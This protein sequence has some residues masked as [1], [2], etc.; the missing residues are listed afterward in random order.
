VHTAQCSDYFFDFTNADA[1]SQKHLLYLNDSERDVRMLDRHPQVR[2]LF[3]KYN[4]AIASSAP[5]ERVF[6]TGALVLTKRRNRLSDTLFE[7]AV[8]SQ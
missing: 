4:T 5:V 6:S 1:S 2:K 8:K 7:T 3:I